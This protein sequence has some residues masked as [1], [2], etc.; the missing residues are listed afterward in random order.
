[1][2]LATVYLGRKGGGNIY[3]FSMACELAN[4]IDQVCI[5]SS[6]NQNLRDWKKLNCYC[7]DTYENVVG[8]FFSL[9][10][11]KKIWKV[12]DA[13]FAF[14]ADLVYFPM[15]HTWS[16]FI[17]SA[18]KRLKPSAQ[19]FATIHDPVLHL[20]E[21]NPYLYFQQRFVIRKSDALI[22]LSSCYKEMLF[23]KH[24]ITDDR[25]LVLPHGIFNY[26]FD[27]LSFEEDYSK[28]ILL[29]DNAKQGVQ[30]VVAFLGRIKRYKGLEVLLRAFQKFEVGKSDVRLVI[31]GEGKLSRKEAKL[32]SELPENKVYVLNRWLSDVEIS[33]L[34]KA[35]DVIV[36]PYICGTQSGVVSMAFAAG[37]PV[38]VSD[39]G[40]L[41]EQV[42]FGK[43]G[44]IT[45]A[46]DVF[47]LSEALEYIYVDSELRKTL[48][49]NIKQYALEELSWRNQA[50]KLYEFMSSFLPSKR[51]DNS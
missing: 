47:S 29:K 14:D 51:V 4:F 23:K 21:R 11:K 37:K 42:G 30:F 28:K 16:P 48:I 50:K 26:Y 22:L 32:I 12:I 8:F 13:I 2:K 10:N 46:G 31:A 41:P 49:N 20:G 19:V 33:Y 44:L 36:A 6:F 9:V 34:V 3:S 7:V 25:I 43:F 15:L 18:I 24:G 45:K 35:S 5:I 27:G 38:I 1:M 39:C 40:G 17:L